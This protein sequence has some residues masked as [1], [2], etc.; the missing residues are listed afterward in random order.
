MECVLSGGVEWDRACEM[1][2]T[3]NGNHTPKLVHE[4]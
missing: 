1:K 3:H 2:A 4:P